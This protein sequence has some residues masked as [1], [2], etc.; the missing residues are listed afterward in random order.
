MSDS[1][2]PDLAERTSAALHNMRAALAERVIQPPAAQ[3]R[4]RARRGQRLQWT[5][6]AA[7]AAV[8]AAVAV[9]VPGWALRN[10]RGVPAPDGTARPAVPA[11]S[12][13][14]LPA[15]SDGAT[16]NDPITHVDPMNMTVTVAANPAA[17]CPSGRVGA[18][19]LAGKDGLVLNVPNVPT[20]AYGDLN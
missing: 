14:P 7:V 16:V 11:P 2:G 17:P 15:A 18:N 6:V 13:P 20:A 5:T 4:G 9:L 19:N 3:L 10:H 12:L 1:H 8:V